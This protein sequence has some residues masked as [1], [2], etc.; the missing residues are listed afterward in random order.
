M[1][2][3]ARTPYD[4]PRIEDV[5]DVQEDVRAQPNRKAAVM[6]MSSHYSHLS[7]NWINKHLDRLLMLDPEALAQVIGYPDPTGE[8]AIRNIE[9]EGVAA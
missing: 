7:P 9:R 5:R 2:T 3:C 1:H 6:H 8:A 4:R